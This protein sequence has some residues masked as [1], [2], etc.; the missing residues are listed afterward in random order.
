MDETDAADENKRYQDR[1]HVCNVLTS[2]FV[3]RRASPWHPDSG[4][5]DL[6]LTKSQTTILH[7]QK[8]WFFNLMIVFFVVKDTSDWVIIR[9]AH[10]RINTLLMIWEICL[11]LSEDGEEW[12]RDKMEHCQNNPSL[13][14]NINYIKTRYF[15]PR[16]KIECSISIQACVGQTNRL[17]L[18]LLVL[19]TEPK[20]IQVHDITRKSSVP[21]FSQSVPISTPTEFKMS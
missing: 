5:L 9:A 21:I 2:H 17:S 13:S 14:A 7:Q 20:K 12:P 3:T 1:I 4:Y 15:R 19:L 10:A 18:W 11:R 6:G 16:L 8:M